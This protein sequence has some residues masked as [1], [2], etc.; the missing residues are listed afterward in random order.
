MMGPFL[1]KYWKEVCDREFPCAKPENPNESWLQFYRKQ[2]DS[3]KSKISAAGTRLRDS[4]RGEGKF[5]F[6]CKND[7]F[8]IIQNEKFINYRRY[9]LIL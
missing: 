4:Y 8:I 2:V 3:S 6:I 7:S 1:E 9:Q 5:L